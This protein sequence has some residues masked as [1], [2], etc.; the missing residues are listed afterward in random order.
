MENEG[1]PKYLAFVFVG[2]WGV[3]DLNR[4]G[5]GRAIMQRWICMNFILGRQGPSKL[6]HVLQMN[7]KLGRPKSGMAMA[8]TTATTTA[9]VEDKKQRQF[10]KFSD[11]YFGKCPY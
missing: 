9:R 3:G 5:P 2:I 11:K 6:I 8:M 1:Q 4:G 7:K 10:L